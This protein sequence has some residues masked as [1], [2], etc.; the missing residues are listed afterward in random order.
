[1]N[2]SARHATDIQRMPMRLTRPF[3]PF[4]QIVTLLGLVFAALPAHAGSNLRDALIHA[5]R[6]SHELQAD[7][8][9]QRAT[10]EQLP[11]AQAGW[12][13]TVEARTSAGYKYEDN[14]TTINETS[15]PLSF[16]ITLRQ[17]IFRGFRTQSATAQ[18]H[19]VIAAG[20]QELLGLE[21]DV[22]LK[23][24]TAYMD[25]LRDRDIAR[26]RYNQ[27]VILRK[28]LRG[29]KRRL[30]LGD[31][32]R[33]DVAQ[34]LNRFQSAIANHDNAK[35]DLG[36]SVSGYMR[37]VGRKP[38]SLKRPNLPHKMPLDLAQ[39]IRVA[40][41]YNPEIKKAMHKEVAA[42]HFIKLKRGE[43]LPRVALEAEYDYN[44]TM[45]TTQ[46]TSD[47]AVVRGV[48]TVPLYQAGFVYSKVRE[49]KELA[50]RRRMLIL[51]ARRKIRAQMMRVWN[52][53][54]EAGKKIGTVKAQI[55][56]SIMAVEGVRRET[57]LGSRTTQEV[58]DAERELMNARIAL[59]VARRNHVARA[60]E[61]LA[62]AGRLT[63]RQLRL[64]IPLHDPTIYHDAVDGKWFG[65]TA[66][67]Q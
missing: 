60:Y 55:G 59:A 37:F 26:L 11:Q 42:R 1:M 7:R 16:K 13:P 39:A 66:N 44:S 32:T 3:A 57:L 34:A 27:V 18:A 8:Y 15:D 10:D 19:Q 17:P 40:E 2:D 22:L 54:R 51:N 24:V 4:A 29:A 62:A 53:Y 30:A 47:T 20:R 41:Q 52:R 46:A 31:K 48:L 36:V 67:T 33:T 56:A 61:V 5:Y 14:S 45:T 23:A 38:G 9:R 64:D 35:A 43:L 58:L 25:V 28:E 6:S 63:A 12:H 50:N 49:A 65:T 21:Q